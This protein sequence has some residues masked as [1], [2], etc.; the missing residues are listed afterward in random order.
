MAAPVLVTG[1]AGFIGSHLAR[2][3]IESGRR[4]VG[5]DNFD[6]FYDRAAKEANVAGLAPSHFELIEA[7][8]RDDQAMTSIFLRHRPD[9]AFHIAALAGVRPSIADPARYASVNV[10]GLVR[11]LDAARA[12]G[13]RA[14]VFA[15]SS[16][17]YGNRS[18]VPF[19][20]E[21]AAVEPISPYAAT[22]RA[23]ELMCHAYAH[24][25]DLAIAAVRFFT[26]YGP[27]QR[28][29]LAIAK[30]M[31][32]IADGK[33]VSMFG[34]GTSSRD[35]TFI[36]DIVT[37]VLAARDKVAAQPRGSGY[38]R[39]YN[40]GGAQPV[41]LSE[42]IERIGAVVGRAPRIRREPMQPGDVDR[43]YADLRRSRAELG[44][45]PTT[46]FMTGLRRQWEWMQQAAASP[47]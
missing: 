24:L 7:D 6:P 41:M 34:D 27:A 15:S 29:D 30:F 44:Y 3:L 38:F 43:T 12:S 22:K 16:S 31:R 47:T 36:D 23:G 42:M 46:D 20:E 32:L 5:V 1:A 37:G 2:A 21:D 33:E 39:I 8:V 19:S 25:F 13:C 10:G 26:V 9:A 40:L 18:T 45:W 4:V 28:P 35:Y 17:V 14:I 11:V